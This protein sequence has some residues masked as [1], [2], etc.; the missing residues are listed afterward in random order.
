[1]QN[2]IHSLTTRTRLYLMLVFPVLGL[3]Y[4][5]IAS[6]I[7]NFQVKE[8]SVELQLTTA[9]S[10]LTSAAIHELQKERGMSAGYLGSKGAR[11]GSELN[12]Q[13][14]KTDSALNGLLKTLSVKTSPAGKQA[15]ERLANIARMRSE[16]S[17]LKVEGKASFAYFTASIESLLDYIAEG[18]VSAP[19][20]DA[21]RASLAYVEFLIGKEYAGRE[22]ATLNAAL[23]MNRFDPELYNRFVQLLA[24]QKAHFTTFRRLADADQVRLLDNLDRS[25]AARE[26]DRIRTVAIERAQEGNFG[27]DPGYW[28]GTITGKID[29]LKQIE[30]TLSDNLT[31]L[32]TR[33][34][35][36]A[37]RSFWSSVVVLLFALLAAIIVGMAIIRSLLRDLGGEPAQVREVATQIAQG[38]LVVAVDAGEARP[39][40]VLGTL[41]TMRD[42][43]HGMVS[44]IKQHS[45]GIA[46]TGVSLADMS[47]QTAASVSHQSEAAMEIAAATEQMSQSVASISDSAAET[48]RRSDESGR[49]SQ[50][51]AEVVAKA[52]KEIA[53]MASAVETSAE[54][55]RSLGVESEQIVGIVRVIR[56][57]SD[58]TNLLALNAAIEA[59]RAGEQGRGFAVVADEVRKLAERTSKATT[60]IDVMIARIQQHTREAVSNMERQVAHVKEGVQLTARSSEA[61]LGI[62]ASSREVGDLVRNMSLTLQEQSATSGE[63][64]GKIEQIAERS[65]H[66]KD[67]TEST[68]Q[69][70]VQLQELA[71]ALL[72]TVERFKLA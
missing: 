72:R 33:L 10:V 44:I 43:L 12:V 6:A 5:A 2:L 31:T 22:R 24:F 39:D 48:Q 7:G 9:G 11:F 46:A 30:D 3:A 41:A 20:E 35:S 38:N 13:R 52:S 66:N 56:E 40:S 55:V 34:A 62:H 70:A 18:T 37:S 28:F 21:L 47:R 59:A 63:I 67:M 53:D 60:E 27:I 71:R 32:G 61:M 1:M 42:Q 29:Q 69:S 65:A 15:S 49:L 36:S 50:D 54:T 25:D 58:Q 17:D 23:T 68:A 57:I 8:S 19:N 26:V 14:A 64:A 4:F 45:D 16:I 51:G